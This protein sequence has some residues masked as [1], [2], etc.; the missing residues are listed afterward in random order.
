MS[1]FVTLAPERNFLHKNVQ[2]IR[3]IARDTVARVLQAFG[4]HSN[5]VL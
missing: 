4:H 2:I 3:A 5:R 1:S